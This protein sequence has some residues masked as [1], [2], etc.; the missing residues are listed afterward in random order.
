MEKELISFNVQYK[1]IFGNVWQT[2][3]LGT[4]AESVKK[5]MTKL[6][7]G[8]GVVILKVEKKL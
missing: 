5:E 4:S 1:D 2:E 3:R 8:L 7:S 6:M